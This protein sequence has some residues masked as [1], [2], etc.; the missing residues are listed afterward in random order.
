M[1][2]ATL[3][4]GLP[5]VAVHTVG[6]EVSRDELSASA[7]RLGKLLAES[8]LATG[9]VVAAML[10]NDATT[11]A[12]LFGTWHA[13][14]VYTPL[15]PRAADPEILAQLETLRPVAIITTPAL[16]Q[17]FSTHHLPVITGEALSW[18]R[19]ASSGHSAGEP[20]YDDDVALLQ[21]TS[22]TTGPPKPVPLRHSTVL[23]LIDRLLAKLRGTKPGLENASAP[24]K[25]PPMPNLVPLSLSLWAG[26]YQVLF[27]FRAGSGVVL[28]DRFSPTDFAALVRRHQLR[29]TVLPPAALTMVLHDDSVADLSPLKIVRSITAPLSPVQA[30]RFRDKFGVIVLNSYGQTEL[31][32]E[33]V[34]WSAADAREWGETKL[35]SVGRPLPGIDVTI[36]DDEVMVRTPTTA[37]R[38]IDPAFLDRLTDDGWFHT[39]D[40][41]WFDDDGF[42]W[43]DGRVSDMINRG[44]LKVFPGTVEDVL[45][46]ADGV[47]EAAVV[48]VPD[49]R[50]G[51]VPWAFVVRGDES[52]S[53][54]GLVS[55]CRERLTPYRVPVRIVFVEQLPR[56]DVGKVVKRDL[57]ALA[58]V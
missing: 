30:R 1:N 36:A 40:L 11:I 24:P 3:L 29:S 48:G 19:V 28:M 51:E 6:A 5:D 14:G 49:E 26:I 7:Q 44:G 22:G 21:F 2:L 38:K 45:L 56:N 9:Q 57:A 20:C 17:R 58:D 35:G 10:P 46:A 15:N 54:A 25:R 13:G 27:A 55:W 16:A 8:G 33:V 12:A 52:V 43:L 4:D 18:T 37:A 34:G 39:G 53:E 47:R 50:L 41:G 32:G 31:G 23:D 42:L